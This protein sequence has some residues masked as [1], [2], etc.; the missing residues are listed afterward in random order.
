MSSV[1][2]SLAAF[3]QDPELALQAE[4]R[5]DRLRLHIADTLGMILQG[6]S[7][8]EG[9]TALALGSRLAGWCASARL[10]EADDIHLTSCTTPGSVVVPTA[11]HLA[12]AGLFQTW[13]DFATA[14]LAG[15][16]TLIRIG[17]AI[18]GPRI[19]ARKIWPTLFAAPVGAAAVASRACGL[20]GSQTAGALATALAAST[21]IAPPA[22]TSNS[23][24]C[25]SLGFAAE[26]GVRAAMAARA[27][28]LGDVQLIERHAGRIAGMRISR[29][30]LLQGAGLHF[31]FDEIE[32]KPYPIARQGLAAVEACRQLAG[33]N[34][35]GITAITV[36]VP[37]A[38]ARVI[39]H[40]SWPANR[41]QSIAGIQYQIALALLA[42]DRLMDFARTPPF[43][44]PALRSLAA[45]VR[46]CTDARLETR[47]PDTWPARVVVERSGRRQAALVSIPRGD[48]RNPI[49]WE[50][51][52]AKAAGYR[53][54]LTW[55]RKARPQDP[56]PQLL[57]A[58]P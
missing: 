44:T 24:R 1:L 16:E 26:H 6:A 9:K 54:A 30:R 33:R 37:S 52:L 4:I 20:N 43:V 13:G 17:Y 48:T 8:A 3:V 5:M 25:I 2:E 51:V 15:Y 7:L 32:L 31:F 38:Q 12:A 56:V 35:K 29:R 19:L 57:D 46:V 27:G 22:L 23:S 50:D 10:T 55:I 34:T 18:D 45:K 53:T 58:L 11:L 41:M 28:A 14:V 47:Y 39:D 40:P 21:G 49:E 42:P 36:S